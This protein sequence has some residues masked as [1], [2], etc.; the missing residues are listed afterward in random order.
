MNRLAKLFLSIIVCCLFC[1]FTTNAVWSANYFVNP[2]CASGCDGTTL[3]KG[4]VDYTALPW[5]TIDDE[6]STLYFSGGLPGVGQT[7]SSSFYIVHK[8]TGN[9]LTI[10]PASASSDPDVA[11][12]SGLVTFTN[13]VKLGSSLNSD[14]ECQNLVFSGETTIGSGTRNIKFDL[15]D[16]GIMAINTAYADSVNNKLFYIEVTGAGYSGSPAGFAITGFNEIGYIYMYENHVD[17]DILPTF[18]ACTGYG[19]SSVHHSTMLSGGTDVVRSGCGLDVYENYMDCSDSAWQYDIMQY[20]SDDATLQYFRVWNNFLKS[21]DQMIF[22]ENRHTVC[23]DCKTTHIRIFN[24]TFTTETSGL[25][26]AIG[27]FNEDDGPPANTRNIEDV[28]IVYNTFVNTSYALRWDA[29]PQQTVSNFKMVGNIFYETGTVSDATDVYWSSDATVIFD[30][31]LFY[32]SGAYTI[33]WMNSDWSAQKTYTALSGAG[34]FITEHPTFDKNKIG[35]P[36]FADALFRLQAGSPAIASG[37]NLSALTDMPS[38]WP[39]DKDGNSR[40]VGLWTIGAYEYGASP[41]TPSV[42]EGITIQGGI[43]Q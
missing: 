20:Y 17:S 25:G 9:T 13:L 43:I 4:F 11:S 19:T 2:N 10:R 22:L 32:H 18:G 27:I 21:T 3:A 37:E 24:N 36:L 28:H 42:S 39:F 38:G 14:Y 6:S 23:A 5:T 41:E 1:I 35:D 33:Q 30:S 7:Y 16:A 40:P 29:A 12:H 8:T 31:N 34:G 26:K 15:G